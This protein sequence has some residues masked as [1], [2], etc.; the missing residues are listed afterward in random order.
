[1]RMAD[2]NSDV[3]LFQRIV[4]ETIQKIVGIFHVLLLVAAEIG[5]CKQ[6][7]VSNGC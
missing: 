6:G 7:G 2:I 4:I 3:K 5:S 1:M